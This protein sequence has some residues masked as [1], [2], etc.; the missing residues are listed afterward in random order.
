MTVA[1]P[2][3]AGPSKEV[4]EVLS[5]SAEPY[6]PRSH[7]WFYALPAWA[8]HR[9]VDE[10]RPLDHAEI[11]V[12]KIKCIL[13]V[14]YRGICAVSSLTALN[15][16]VAAG[17]H[18]LGGRTATMMTRK[19]RLEGL[20]NLSKIV[21]HLSPKKHPPTL[22]PVTVFRQHSP[23]SAS[24]VQIHLFRIHYHRHVRLHHHTIRRPVR[25]SRATAYNALSFSP[26]RR[27]MGYGIQTLPCPYKYGLYGS[28]QT[29]EK[30]SGRCRGRHVSRFRGQSYAPACWLASSS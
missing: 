21:H 23:L 26:S 5:M 30:P 25:Q 4:S 28:G 1:F 2:T 10:T 29:V 16:V 9:R 3:A 12:W 27:C 8:L 11:W 20:Y 24:T 18:C 6:L 13:I 15:R 19:L 17:N 22:Y 7:T 14:R